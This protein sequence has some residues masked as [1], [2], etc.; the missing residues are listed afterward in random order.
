M[1]ALTNVIIYQYWQMRRLAGKK[2]NFRFDKSYGVGGNDYYHRFCHARNSR[3]H[4]KKN[5]FFTPEAIF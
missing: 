5:F 4:Q 3:N 1:S 2:I